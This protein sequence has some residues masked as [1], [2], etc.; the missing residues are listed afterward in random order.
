[1]YLK[2]LLTI[3]Y[4]QLYYTYIIQSKLHATCRNIYILYKKFKFKLNHI[5]PELATESTQIHSTNNY[6]KTKNVKYK[7]LFIYLFCLVFFLI[8]QF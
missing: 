6:F 3:N 1:M 5:H 4:P 2:A 8:N 7:K